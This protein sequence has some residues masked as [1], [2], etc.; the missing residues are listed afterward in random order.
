VQRQDWA[1]I[2]ARADAV[3]RGENLLMGLVEMG[4]FERAYLLLGMEQA[5]MALITEPDEMSQML[6]VVADYKIELIRKFDDVADPDMLWFGDDWG[7]Q[8]ALFMPPAT[9]RRVIKPHLKRI[10]DC[11]KQRGILINQHSCG[12]IDAIFGD[13]VELGA[14]LWNP[15]QPCNDLARLKRDYGDRISF[16][17]GMDS[18]FVLDRPGVTAEEVRAEARRVIDILAPGGGYVAG[19]SQRVP[20]DP[21]LVAALKDEVQQYGREIYDR[22]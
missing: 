13:L 3:D 8:Q 4:L 17:G 12:K 9:W 18:Q 1:S 21:A 15:C 19:P 7:T 6:G 10:Y 5:L 11:M 20:R 22:R 2:R 14:D 16:H